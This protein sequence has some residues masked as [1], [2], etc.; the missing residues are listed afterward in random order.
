MI[1]NNYIKKEKTQDEW[2]NRLERERKMRGGK[3]NHKNRTER[4]GSN[5]KNLFGDS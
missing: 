4:K 1:N 5:Q 3:G 2:M